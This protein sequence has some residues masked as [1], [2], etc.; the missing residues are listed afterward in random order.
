MNEKLKKCP[1]C[2]S[3]VVFAYNNNSK[4]GYYKC[5]NTECHFRLGMNYSEKEIALQGITLNAVCGGC[6]SSLTIA[7]GP[8][9]LYA[10]CLRCDYDTTPNMVYGFIFRK[11]ANAHNIEAQEEIV[12]LKKAYKGIVNE[13]YSFDDF[14]GF[15]EEIQEY[16][17]EI[18]EETQDE[19]SVNVDRDRFVTLY[20]KG[21]SIAQLSQALNITRSQ[22]RAVKRELLSENVISTYVKKNH[23]RLSIDSLENQE[24]KTSNKKQ[25]TSDKKITIASTPTKGSALE[26]VINFLKANL[27][28]KLSARDICEKIEVKYNT[29]CNYLSQLRMTGVVKIVGHEGDTNPLEILYAMKESPL[30]ELETVSDE[31]KYTTVAKFYDKYR[32][33]ISKSNFKTSMILNKFVENSGIKSYAFLTNQGLRKVY[34]IS[35]LLQLVKNAN[36]EEKVSSKNMHEESIATKILNFLNKDIQTPYSFIQ[37]SEKLKLNEG[38]VVG[39]VKTLRNKGKVKIVDNDGAK[40]LIQVTE[41]PLPELDIKSSEQ[42]VSLYNFYRNNTKKLPSIP[43]YESIIK[44]A[45]LESHKIITRRG[46]GDGYDINELKNLFLNKKGVAEIVEDAEIPASSENYLKTVPV[47]QNNGILGFVTSVFKKNT[48]NVTLNSDDLISF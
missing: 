14:L 16:T 42:Y 22:A 43:K 5:S 19:A 13:D 38:S 30:P 29:V 15:E 10:T 32:K 44:E 17:Q 20:N 23:P 18:A 46:I 34:L 39:T 25:Q 33:L 1:L 47:I 40:M 2:G 11:H 35:D 3:E 12:E 8:K 9:G 6:G 21:Y 45:G 48:K 26:A 24:K 31:N 37:I 41:S 36:V 4:Q 7:N 27:N 28:K